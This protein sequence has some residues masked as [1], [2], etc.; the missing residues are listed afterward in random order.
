MSRQI[1]DQSR[2]I[3]MRFNDW[4][5]VNHFALWF[6]VGVFFPRPNGL[7]IV[8]ILSI[9]WEVGEIVASKIETLRQLLNRYW[10]IP[11]EYWNEPIENKITDIFLNLLGYAIATRYVPY[12]ARWATV[13]G[14]AFIGSTWMATL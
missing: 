6:I 14:I 11:E 2:K 8:F 7:L 5:S 12:D 10:I 9:L 13:A 3:N 1:L 4:M